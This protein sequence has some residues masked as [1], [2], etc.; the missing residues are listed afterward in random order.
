MEAESDGNAFVESYKF[1]E[2]T[3]NWIYGENV[4]SSYSRLSSA[5]EKCN[6][7]CRVCQTS[8]AERIVRDQLVQ[9]LLDEDIVPELLEMHN[10]NNK[11]IIAK[12][13][14]INTVT[15]IILSLPRME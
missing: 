2:S 9:V 11:D 15:D 5:T 13:E 14:E 8:Y 1:F 6:F 4:H 12:Y 10:P 7:K 3:K